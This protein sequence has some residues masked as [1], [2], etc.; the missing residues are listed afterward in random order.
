VLR[1]LEDVL[2]DTWAAGGG[3]LGAVTIP[4]SHPEAPVEA[5]EQIEAL[6][7]LLWVLGRA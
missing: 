2:I 1:P 5:G 4:S 3:D 6:L 7:T